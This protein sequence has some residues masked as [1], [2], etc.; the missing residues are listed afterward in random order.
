MTFEIEKFKR[1]DR[2]EVK[3]NFALLPGANL[4]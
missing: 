1:V 2:T 3:R 4:V